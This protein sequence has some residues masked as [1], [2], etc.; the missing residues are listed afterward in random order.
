MGGH[1]VRGET[2]LALQYRKK[3]GIT[4]PKPSRIN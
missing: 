1:N 2:R 3:R 4:P